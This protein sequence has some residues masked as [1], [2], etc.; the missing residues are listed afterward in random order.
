MAR[1]KN[2]LTSKPWLYE[3]YFP[4]SGSRYMVLREMYV[5][6]KLPTAADQTK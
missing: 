1:R 6:F 3:Y 2:I 5:E 4:P